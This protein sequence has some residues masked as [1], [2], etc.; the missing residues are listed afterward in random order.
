[1]P[2]CLYPKIDEIIEIARG[3]IR[4]RYPLYGNAWVKEDAPYWGVRMHNEVDEFSKAFSDVEKKRKCINIVNLAMMAYSTIDI[5]RNGCK[6][7]VSS[8]DLVKSVDNVL[9]SKCL[10]CNAFV[11]LSM[12]N[13]FDTKDEA[14]ADFDERRK[15]MEL[16]AE[17]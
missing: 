15:R 5:D 7:G 3:V 17:T 2:V 4:E 16:A 13:I 11:W 9:T 1:M 8:K 14:I 10:Q 6:H 12:G